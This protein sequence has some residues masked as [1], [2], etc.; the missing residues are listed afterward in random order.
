MLDW[1]TTEGWPFGWIGIGL[2]AVALWAVGRRRGRP[3]R[4]RPARGSDSGGYV[5]TDFDGQSRR[6][7]DDRPDRAETDSGDDGGGGDGG[8]D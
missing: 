5:W 2:V 6:S 7:D 1:F 4:R 8:G 3:A